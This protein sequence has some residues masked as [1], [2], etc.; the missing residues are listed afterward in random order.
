MTEDE[1]VMRVAQ[2]T[3]NY[4]SKLNKG[5]MSGLIREDRGKFTTTL[6]NYYSKYKGIAPDKFMTN[7]NVTVAAELADKMIIDY[8]DKL[9][10]DGFVPTRKELKA[11]SNIIKVNYSK[12]IVKN[13]DSNFIKRLDNYVNESWMHMIPCLEEALIIDEKDYMDYHIKNLD[14]DKKVIELT[15]RRYI[16]NPNVCV[17]FMF[18]GQVHFKMKFTEEAENGIDIEYIP[19]F[20]EFPNAIYTMKENDM[21]WNKESREFWDNVIVPACLKFKVNETDHLDHYMSKFLGLFG[22]INFM[23]HEEPVRASGNKRKKVKTTVESGNEVVDQRIKL[24]RIN[25]LG[26][27]ITSEKKPVASN[28][29]SVRKYK[30]AVWRVRG[31]VSHSKNGKEFWVPEHIARRHDINATNVKIPRTIIS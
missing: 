27:E 13:P 20:K 1:E 16:F 24:K 26:L 29:T 12:D 30:T 7:V 15:T 14:L 10:D 5:I 4:I 25:T 28:E 21:G 2:E 23:L 9:V 6:M 3:A 8:C 22:Y 31:H 18:V 11:R 17:K 19:T